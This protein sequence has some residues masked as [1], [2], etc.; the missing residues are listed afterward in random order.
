MILTRSW[1]ASVVL[2]CVCLML[3]LFESTTNHPVLVNEAQNVSGA[4]DLALE[5]A[6]PAVTVD[7]KQLEAAVSQLKETKNQ[8]KQQELAKQQALAAQAKAMEEKQLKAQQAVA[9]L[10]E[11]ANQLA[12]KHK[13]E[14]IEEKK[15]LQALAKEKALE[16]QRVEALKQEQVKL[17][18]AQAL[19]AVAHAQEEKAHLAK[20]A[21]EK[22]HKQQLLAQEKAASEAKQLAEE[23]RRAAEALAAANSERQ[24]MMS[25][26]VDKYK[27]LIISAISRQWILPDNVNPNLSCQF[28]IRLAPDGMV[29]EVSLAKTSG[30]PI[31][32]RSAQTAI[33][34]ASPLPVPSD[35]TL[36]NVFRDIS[37]TVRPEQQRG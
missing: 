21:A 17:K 11:E 3:L 37:L 16:K 5:K 19:E 8:A 9:K 6:I 18:K 34:K 36:F 2:H 30:D 12:I 25:G 32:D 27:A 24:A 13:K 29:L 15:R 31:L 28:R 33:Y 23:K 22:E 20:I 26:E 7:S 4:S 1:I 10:K 35:P 14:V